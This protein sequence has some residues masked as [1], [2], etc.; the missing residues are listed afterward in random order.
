MPAVT[1]MIKPT[2]ALCNLR[3]KYCFYADV[4]EHRSVPFY[5]M[6]SGQTAEALVRGVFG[7]ADRAVSFVFQGGEPT[8]AGLPFFRRFGELVSRYNTRGLPV[9][10]SLQTNGTVLDGEWAEFLRENRYLVGLSMDGTREIHD[11][12]RVDAEGRGTYA[13]V[14]RAADLLRTHGVDFNILCVVNNFIARYPRRVFEALKKYRY[15]QFIPCIDPFDGGREV[16]SLT[17]E[18]YTR[19]LRETFALYLAAF[20]AKEPV[21]VRNFDNYIGILLGEPAENCAM[22]GRCAAYFLVEGDGGVYPCDFYVLDRW[23]LGN[24]RERTFAEMAESPVMQTFRAES[25]PVHERCRTCRFFAL[26]RGGCKRDREP[27]RDGVPAL[28]RFCESYRAFFE[29]A[30][31]QMLRMATEIA[32]LCAGG[33]PKR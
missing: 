11:S 22:N 18:R 31:P 20:E 29:E 14:A 24:V 23:K 9:H 5:G 10:Y 3:C 21:S 16:Y 1:V 25:L 15:L 4:A 33:A 26:C 17:P 28:N 30:Y 13:A 6:M 8:L 2:S 27:V 7:Y 32:R 19:F 12:L